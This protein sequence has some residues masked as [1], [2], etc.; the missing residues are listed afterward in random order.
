MFVCQVEGLALVCL[1]VDCHIPDR[2]SIGILFPLID[3]AKDVHRTIVDWVTCP[4]PALIGVCHGAN[5]GLSIGT[6]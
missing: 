6:Y 2:Y 5:F 3:S 1:T 4:F